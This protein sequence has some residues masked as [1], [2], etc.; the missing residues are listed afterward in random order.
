MRLIFIRHPES[1]KNTSGRFSSYENTE[2]L[3]TLGWTQVNSIKSEIQALLDNGF[4]KKPIALYS[5]TSVRSITLAKELASI[6]GSKINEQACLN[7]IGSGSVTGLNEKQMNKVAPGYFHEIELYESGISNAYTIKHPGEPPACFEKRVSLL[8]K[9]IETSVTDTAIIIA[10][11]SALTA[12]FINYAR[13]KKYYPQNFYGY[14]PFDNA[15]FSIVDIDNGDINI[16]GIN[17]SVEEFDLLQ[18][19]YDYNQVNLRKDAHY[20]R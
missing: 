9:K 1:T 13:R 14:I 15:S 11:K 10:H 20:E 2:P 19:K 16:I 4:I 17:K 7:S 5:A 6:C 8:L 3:T 18:R 12:I